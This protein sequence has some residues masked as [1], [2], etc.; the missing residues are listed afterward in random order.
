MRFRE[1]TFNYPNLF[2]IFIITSLTGEDGAMFFE[3]LRELV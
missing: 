3:Q 2:L 1:I